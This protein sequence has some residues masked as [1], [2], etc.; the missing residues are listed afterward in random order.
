MKSKFSK[1]TPTYH[2]GICQKLTRDT[3]RGEAGLDLC[4]CCLLSAYAE[5]AAADYGVDSEEH[6][7]ALLN[8]GEIQ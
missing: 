1:H 6:K 4:A 7:Q 3:G 5:N 8:L 2:C